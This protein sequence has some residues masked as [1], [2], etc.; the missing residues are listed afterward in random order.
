MT[1]S[2]KSVRRTQSAEGKKGAQSSVD[3]SGRERERFVSCSA[4]IQH[5]CA[6]EPFLY[7]ER[8]HPNTS[9]QKLVLPKLIGSEAG[10]PGGPPVKIVAKRPLL[11][12]ENTIESAAKCPSRVK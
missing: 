8:S 1:Y 7:P 10:P 9:R 6:H 11:H 5:D 12:L 4:L 3:S 2:L